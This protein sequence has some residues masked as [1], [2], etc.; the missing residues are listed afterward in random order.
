MEGGGGHGR[1][2]RTHKRL[3]GSGRKKKKKKNEKDPTR[4]G[5]DGCRHAI[6]AGSASLATLVWLRWI[7]RGRRVLY[8]RAVYSPPLDSVL[9]IAG[10]IC[11]RSPFFRAANRRVSSVASNEERLGDHFRT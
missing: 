9:E 11:H 2:A 10:R 3:R 1:E 7:G 8:V 5:D 6:K 4:G